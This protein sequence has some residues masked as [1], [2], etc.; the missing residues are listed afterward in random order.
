[1]TAAKA[2]E[3]L[4]A[5]TYLQVIAIDKSSFAGSVYTS[6]SSVFFIVL[7]RYVFQ[8]VSAF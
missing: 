1:M 5:S 3:G 7:H 4:V 2:S 6:L 8:S